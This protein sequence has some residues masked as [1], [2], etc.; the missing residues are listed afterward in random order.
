[1][2]KNIKLLRNIIFLILLLV[3]A[4]IIF[5]FHITPTKA[6][7]SAL[8]DHDITMVQYNSIKHKNNIYYI[9][10][11]TNALILVNVQRTL[12]FFWAIADQSYTGFNEDPINFDFRSDGDFSI[13]YGVRRDRDIGSIQLTLKDDETFNYNLD[14]TDLFFFTY[15]N[16]FLYLKELIA[17]RFFGKYLLVGFEL[18]KIL[19]IPRN[20]GTAIKI[21]TTHKAH[22][23]FQLTIHLSMDIIKKISIKH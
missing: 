21:H 12:G 3:L 20:I 13:V 2:K 11:S 10:H 1:M 19:L 16:D 7:K 15:N 8:K 9:G 14:N 22:I 23:P 6:M 4:G 5:D 17:Y 18:H